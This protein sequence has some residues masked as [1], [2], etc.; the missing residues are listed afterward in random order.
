MMELFDMIGVEGL[1]KGEDPRGGRDSKMGHRIRGSERKGLLSLSWKKIS[2][3]NLH[4]MAS[5]LV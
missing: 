1:L 2:Y 3:R 4:Q 5:E